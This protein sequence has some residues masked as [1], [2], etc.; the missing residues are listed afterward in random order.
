MKF[1]KQGKN[2]DPAIYTAWKKKKI[3]KQTKKKKT[4]ENS[5]TTKNKENRIRK[6]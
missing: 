4:P 1:K 5:R 2:Q 6:I 3:N